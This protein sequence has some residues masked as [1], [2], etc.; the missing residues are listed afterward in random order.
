MTTY[1]IA[2][3]DEAQKLANAVNELIAHGH[4][5]IGGVSIDKH[6]YYMQAMIR[7]AISEEA[8]KKQIEALKKLA[9]MKGHSG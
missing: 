8:V 6:G 7:D 2:I 9:A 3:E 5:P 1:S 4:Q